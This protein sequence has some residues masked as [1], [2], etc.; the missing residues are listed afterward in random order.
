MQNPIKNLEI[1]ITFEKPGILPEKLKT[2]TSSNYHGVDYLF[3][4]ILHTSPTHCLQNGACD[5][6]YFFGSWVIIKNKKKGFH[7]P[8]FLHFFHNARSKQKKN[9]QT[10]FCRRC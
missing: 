10:L 1:L 7:T 3:T 6:F 8:G 5:L 4:S 9:C 2:L